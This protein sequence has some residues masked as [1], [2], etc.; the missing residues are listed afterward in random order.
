VRL[1]YFIKHPILLVTI[2]AVIG[3]GLAVPAAQAAS[4]AADVASPAVTTGTSPAPIDLGVNK[5]PVSTESTLPVNSDGEL[6][7]LRTATSR[8]YETSSGYE[9]QVFSGPVDYQDTSGAWQ[10]ID[11][12]LVSDGTGGYKV[13][14][15]GY[16]L[17]L[18]ASLASPITVGKGAAQLSLRLQGAGGTLSVAGAT[19]TYR[20]A[21]PGVDVA[22]SAEATQV[23][24]TLTL[25]SAAA[26]ANYVYGFTLPKGLS[27]K[28]DASGSVVVT[29]SGGHVLATLP[30]AFMDDAAGSHS[31][32]VSYSLSGSGT[33]WT[34]T[35]T[36]DSAWLHDPSR[37]F[38]VVVDPTATFN[39][40]TQATGCTLSANTPTT[41]KCS[42]STLQVGG[43]STFKSR[44]L[45]RFDA[46]NSVVP[47]DAEIHGSELDLTEVSGGTSTTSKNVELHQITTPWST[48]ATWNTSNGTTAWGSAG[49]DFASSV[50]GPAATTTVTPTTG[51]YSFALSKLV[52]D[53]VTG[54]QANNG[55]EIKT[56]SEGTTGYFNFGSYNAT[57]TSTWPALKVFY[58]YRY[59]EAPW[60]SYWSRNLTDR[61]KLEVNEASGNLEV[62][63]VDANISGPGPKYSLSRTYNSRRS[64]TGDDMGRGWLM[65]SGQDVS[66]R[67]YPDAMMYTADTGV[68][69][70]FYENSSGGYDAAAGMHAGLTT[71]DSLTYTMTMW[72]AGE[73]RTFIFANATSAS[74]A[75]LAAITDRNGVSTTF[76]YSATQNSPANGQPFLNS[77][78]DA[79]GRG[80]TFTH[81]GSW[82]TSASDSYGRTY[83]YKYTGNDLTEYDDPNGG[84]TLYGYDSND[85]LTQIT[86][87]AT[88]A[89]AAGNVIAITYAGTSSRVQSI[90]FVSNP[91]SVSS[92][93]VGPTY[94]FYYTTNLTHSGSTDTAT[95][96][97][98]DPNGDQSVYTYD[99]TD[100]VVKTTDPLNH[101]VQD[102]Y[103]SD[104]DMTSATDAGVGSPGSANTMST[105]DTAANHFHNTAQVIPTGA[106]ATATY[107]TGSDVPSSQTNLQGATIAF[108]YDAAGNP[109]QTS[110]AGTGDTTHSTYQGDPGVSCGASP[111]EVCSQTSALGYATTYGYD[112]AGDITSIA[113]PSPRN[114]TTSTYDSVGRT[115]T[116]TDG[117]GQKT[118]YSYNSLDHVTQVLSAGATTCSYTSGNCL[119]YSYDKSGELTSQQDATGVTQFHFDFMGRQTSKSLPGLATPLSQTW[120]AASNLASYTDTNGTVTYGYNVAD[121]LVNLAEPGG[122]CTTTPVTLCTT[123]DND[124]DG[125]IVATHYPDGVTLARTLDSSGRLTEIKATNSGGTLTDFNYAYNLGSVDT[126]LRQTMTDG[127]GHITTYSYDN[128][129]ELTQ[130][131]EKV[132]STGVVTAKW[133]YC[134]DSDENRTSVSTSTATA[135]TC[136]TT[137]TTSYGY[138]GADELTSLN[139]ST[140]GWSY[141]AS[142]DE[143]SGVGSGTRTSE[144]YTASGQLSGMTNSG[145]PVSFS[146]IGLTNHERSGLTTSSGTTNF[147]TGSLG[148]ISQTN[149][150][151]ST[152]LTRDPFG[153]LVG[154]RVVSGGTTSH[155]YY[156]SDAS[157]S[158]VGLVDASGAL[159]DSY[160]YDPFGVLRTTSELAP[161]PFR[162]IGGVYDSATG[163]YK[164]GGRY[165]DPSLGRFTQTDPMPTDQNPYVYSMNSPTNYSDPSG[166]TWSQVL[167]DHTTIIM[168]RSQTRFL[169]SSNYN[170]VAFCLDMLSIA[171]PVV[172][173]VSVPVSLVMLVAGWASSHGNC[174]RMQFWYVAWHHGAELSISYYGKDPHCYN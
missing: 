37:S 75:G 118:T 98:Y 147:A 167:Y 73:T 51:V 111:G 134:Y 122:S 1:S 12:S 57:D 140:S 132:I 144:T 135:A 94:S 154:M 89:N 27:P 159:A 48:S 173:F 33:A 110:N 77:A 123:F 105:M 101:V 16:S 163:L 56:T 130:A 91:T 160:S 95:N 71:T 59:G 162:Y 102:G 93:W 126:D 74:Q 68:Q 106:T 65:S 81:P 148:L 64:F 168:S 26:P 7:T 149:S 25:A 84:I 96:T 99:D 34:L 69:T 13:K 21:L 40:A 128:L 170:T 161:Q 47:A 139:G 120:D 82:I 29:D 35:V 15:N 142:G 49:G 11:D 58:A 109:T 152:A 114:A 85:N 9:A 153:N 62:V 63:N 133:T 137:P 146:Y 100:R 88:D 107:P 54:A 172:L 125:N 42:T 79:A 166:A 78:S 46:L 164:L 10:K 23:K 18:P 2:S 116:R 115:L 171:F 83:T 158:I 80:V 112:A 4:K 104:N 169:F 50:A 55:V 72:D 67:R 129:G 5:P 3:A 66:L 131:V 31:E 41:S 87:P 43:N 52:A 60:I 165:Y 32:N 127:S 155:Y 145:S 53:W 108:T 17:D 28:V 113:P 174:E 24:E 136:T 20:G 151:G 117:L 143:T 39:L 141:N 97:F 90:E 92:S 61:M 121:Q 6:P 8:T 19:A 30:K 150:S 70:V 44:S 38:P 156:V 45:L 103:N 119:T 36:P 138:N 86:T 22:Y 157:Q 124:N 76:T 14:A